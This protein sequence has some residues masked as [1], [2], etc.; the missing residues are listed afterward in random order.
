MYACK[1]FCTRL[2][3]SGLLYDKSWLFEGKIG[4]NFMKKNFIKKNYE[5]MKKMCFKIYKK[6]WLQTVRL[7]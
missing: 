4:L 3:K 6:N 1:N 7:F 5:K 2:T